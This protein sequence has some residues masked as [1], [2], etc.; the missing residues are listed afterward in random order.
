MSPTAF[1]GQLKPFELPDPLEERRKR[2]ELSIAESQAAEQKQRASDENAIRSA[3]KPV[4]EVD[5]STGAV[6]PR[7]PRTEE[8]FTK[9]A[10]VNP[11]AAQ[12]FAKG[13]HEQADAEAKAKQADL[14]AQAEQIKLN[15][16]K[17]DDIA[18]IVG[19]VSSEGSLPLA[20]QNLIQNG[21]PEAAKQLQ[22]YRFGTPEFKTFQDQTI[23]GTQD[24]KTKAE[25]ASRALDDQHKQ[26]T[27]ERA[28]AKE[29]FEALVRPY[30]L[31]EA[32]NK[33]I[34]STPDP[35]TG[36]TP[37]QTAQQTS[38]SLTPDFK[39]YQLALKGGFKG[40]FEQWQDHDANRRRSVNNTYVSA[41]APVGADGKPRQAT[42][43][44][45]PADVRAQVQEV[46]DYNYKLPPASRNNPVN[47]AIRDWV[48]RLGPTTGYSESQFTNRNK[49]AADFGASGQSGKA[50]TSTDTALSHLNT[51]SEAGKSLKSGD[52]KQ[53]NRLANFV[54]AQTGSA[55][56]TV[57]DSIVETVAPEIS[58]AVIGGVGG[59]EDRRQMAANF[60]RNLS[61][62][63][64]EGAIGAN[65]TLLGARFKKMAG[66]YESDMGHPLKRKLS[67]ESQGVLDRYSGT[68]PQSRIKIL[69]VEDA[70]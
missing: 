65:A 22:Q 56:P 10:A 55:A 9:I 8:I 28:A 3:F 25:L 12:A 58:K 68:K 54:G 46:L 59:V 16:Q 57:Y 47:M 69:S 32:Q 49:I 7:A 21:H 42:I 33:A 61:D 63:A 29:K 19:S 43:D 64:R 44:D 14:V 67:T 39:N 24:A 62:Q 1:L 6:A 48:A 31:T 2:A 30:Q 23:A 36:L 38:S 52:I 40:T 41:P 60:S 35:K 26:L 27:E 34:T 17:G 13:A 51:I 50:M 11:R 4:P 20:I 66:A 5:P 45:V 15:T 37:E 18:K 70:R 53:L